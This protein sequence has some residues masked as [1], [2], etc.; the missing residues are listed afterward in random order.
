MRLT[1]VG[2]GLLGSCLLAAGALGGAVAASLVIDEAPPGVAEPKDLIVAVSTADVDDSHAA[3]LTVSM[4]ERDPLRINTAGTTTATHCVPGRA[5]RSGAEIGAI[6][7][8]PV[9]L[10]STKVPLWRDL[11]GSDA[12]DDVTA[13]QRELR[14]LGYS[15]NTSGRVD[16]AT[17]TAVR[18]WLA[19]GSPRLWSLYTGGD[20]A[21]VLPLSAVVWSPQST[22]TPTK[23]ELRLGS[24]VSRGD[25]V[26]I[27]VPEVSRIALANPVVA[28][29]GRSRI[30]TVGSV[31]VVVD[32]NGAVTDRKDVA[33]LTGTPEFAAWLAAEGK[34]R[35]LE[36][37]LS[38]DSSLRV[39]M[40]PP[41]AVL[42][43]NT[44]D[45]CVVSP[46]GVVTSVRVVSSK[47][48]QSLVVPAD[49]GAALPAR[50]VVD[51]T[52]SRTCTSR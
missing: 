31:K 16:G 12:G 17:R 41:A 33:A 47:L 38:L 6:D 8:R 10:L 30:L 50:V 22:V 37:T 39:G 3:L 32:K 26:L 27:P 28:L 46:D 35:R 13:V 23:C 43:V 52:G 34:D 42:G 40:V 21:M 51:R 5:L 29:P 15:A 14:R 4:T 2:I 7:G 49:P 9:R 20:S 24:A 36:G 18:Q 1:W 25:Q 44:S 48:G 45:P 19:K 11:R